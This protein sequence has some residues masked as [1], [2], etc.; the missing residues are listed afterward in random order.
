MSL[1]I[2][3]KYLV[4]PE[5]IPLPATGTFLKQGYLNLDPERTVRVRVAGQEAWI[6]I[7]GKT[8]NAT[9]LEFEYPLPLSDAY[10]MLEDLC[11]QVIEKTRYILPAGNDLTWEIDVFHGPNAP[12]IVAEIELPL[13]DSPFEHPEWLGEEVTDDPRYYNSQLAQHP[14]Q[15]WE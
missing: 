12:L 13:P 10:T 15:S 4:Y 14:Y 1:E 9:R 2:E 8:E 3:R 5:K 7:K 6:T 11:H